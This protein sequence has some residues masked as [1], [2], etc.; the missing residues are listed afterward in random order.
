M[1]SLSVIRFYFYPFFLLLA[2]AGVNYLID[3]Y[4]YFETRIIDRINDN[5]INGGWHAKLKLDLLDTKE[6]INTLIFGTSRAAV[7]RD[8]GYFLNLAINNSNPKI[9]HDYLLI[10]LEKHPEIQTVYLFLDLFPF[11]MG[12]EYKYLYPLDDNLFN[13]KLSCLLSTTTTKRSIEYFIKSYKEEF[14]EVVPISKGVWYYEKSEHLLKINQKAYIQKHLTFPKQKTLGKGLNPDQ[15]NHLSN[16]IAL[17]KERK[18]RY[19]LILNP[20]NPINSEY[21][22]PDLQTFQQK[23]LSLNHLWDCNQKNKPLNYYQENYYDYSHFKPKLAADIMLDLKNGT[24]DICTFN[25]L[26]QKGI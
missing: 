15:L 9:W 3:P 17:L 13:Q 6:P 26:D 24:N 5:K 25:S 22:D 23:V 11:K 4:G 2:I 16:I 18:I 14:K 1:N 8:E 21:N 7:Y 19:Y 20:I 12:Y 10:A